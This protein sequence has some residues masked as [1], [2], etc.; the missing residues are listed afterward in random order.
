[1][2]RSHLNLSDSSLA[3]LHERYLARD[4]AGRLLE[5]ADGMLR[6][7][8]HA[9]AAPASRFGEQSDFWEGRFFERM[10]SREFLPNSP[11]LMNAGLPRGQ[12]AACFVL[13]IED[14][15][16]SIFSALSRMA[17][18]HQSGGG[19]GFS[20]SRMRPREDR[21]RSTGGVASGPLSFM[22]LFDRT[23][24]VIRRGGRRRG[25]NMA[26]LRVDHPD[27]EEFINAKKTP[28]RLEN[29]NLSVGI[30][31]AFWSALEADSDFPLRNPR[32][33]KVVRRIG[34]G[35]LLDKVIQAAWATGDPG[36]LFLD[37]INRDNPTPHLGTI[38][39][40]NPCGEQ[41]LLA[42]ESCTLGSINLA[43]FAA[44]PGLH[45]NRLGA[46]IDDAVVFL[47][48]VIEAN[49]YPCEEIAAATLRTRKIGLGVMGLADLL[50]RI[51]IPYDS[52]EALTLARQ[53]AKFLTERARATSV[54]L[55]K[56]RGSFPA[57]PISSWPQRGFT[58]LRHA[59]VTCVAPT[60][61]ISLLAGTSSS[62]EPFFAIGL[63]RRMLDGRLF[64]EINP[65]V[66][67]EL[68]R[69]GPS[70]AAAIA[71]IREHGS[72]AGV[73]N[74]P[75][76]LRRRFPIAIEIA[77]E[78]HVRMQAAFQG[79]VDAAVSKTVNLPANASFEA[80]RDVFQLAHRLRLKGVTVY[81]YGAR[82]GQALSLIDPD[83][84]SDCRECAV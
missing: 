35:T 84:R 58:A 3:V 76:Q 6:R 11:T 44:P 18:I 37:E 25:A 10:L 81:R 9:I 68:S 79:S 31:D 12:L 23:T 67:S 56:R 22:D 65:L 36:L 13:P 24:A 8:A 15:L 21:V 14:D 62:I 16:D 73:A 53:I 20:F 46:A 39:A 80:V 38:E 2:M 32:S 61:T 29:F 74:L 51:G 4:E 28:G 59:T 26:V 40:T 48:N 83:A 69:L 30:T 33:G 64:I 55:G 54:E 5:D 42:Y 43:V 82:A 1:M 34:A 17:R 60:G 75:V 70:G 78:W 27:I 50:A 49:H 57:F 77:P 47:D 19:T 7:V 52:E 63:S 66:E 45:W 72:L 71:T 41:P